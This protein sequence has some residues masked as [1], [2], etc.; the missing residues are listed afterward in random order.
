MHVSAPLLGTLVAVE[1]IVVWEEVVLLTHVERS[2]R[3][4][5]IFVPQV[6]R[7]LVGQQAGVGEV[8]GVTMS[9]QGVKK[10]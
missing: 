5:N 8:M 6:V 10:R 2:V 9:S 4:G 1:N 3:Y 7:I